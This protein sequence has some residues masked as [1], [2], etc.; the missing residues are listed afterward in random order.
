MTREQIGRAGGQKT[1]ALHG[2]VHME[3][4]GRAGF[5]STCERMFNGDASAYMAYLREQKQ[6]QKLAQGA[7]GGAS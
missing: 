3:A 7:K 1:A 6:R 5:W 4:I 2:S